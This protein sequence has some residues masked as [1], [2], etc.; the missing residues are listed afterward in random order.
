MRIAF[1]SFLSVK[2]NHGDWY[3]IRFNSIAA[4]LLEGYDRAEMYRT[5]DY[6]VVEPTK[7]ITKRSI[8]VGRD[9]HGIPYISMNRLVRSEGF[10]H[11][12]MF[13]GTRYVVK[14]NKNATRIYIC[15]K[16]VVEADGKQVTG[17]NQSSQASVR[18]T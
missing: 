18:G 7:E 5:Q 3:R 6:I 8:G 12:R 17:A 10:L 1:A 16:E 13:D 4:R 14:R 11:E 15:L 2:S 9:N